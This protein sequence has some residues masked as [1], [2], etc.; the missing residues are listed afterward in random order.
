MA[1]IT[2]NWLREFEAQISDGRHVWLADAPERDGGSDAGPRALEML[3]GALGASVCEAAR[4]YALARNLPVEDVIVEVEGDWGGKPGADAECCAIK[5]DAR[6]K[7]NLSDGDLRDLRD[8]A[9][10]CPVARA[11]T[12]ATAIDT[13]VGKL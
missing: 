10:A 2:A 9:A 8:A 1:K 13:Q 6:F 5:V 7:G 11:I 12:G 3:L 4:R